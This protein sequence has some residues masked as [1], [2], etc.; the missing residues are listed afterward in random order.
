MKLTRILIVILLTAGCGN[1]DEFVVSR[2]CDIP[3]NTTIEGNIGKIFFISNGDESVYYIGSPTEDI[4]GGYIPCSSASMDFLSATGVGE[5][6]VF[7]GEVR[8]I[9]QR[10]GESVVDPL[11][12]GIEIT[13]ISLSNE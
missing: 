8:T 10:E 2:V 9:E 1:N 7:S 13:E 3:V 11:Y 4:A 5:L 12:L 6:V